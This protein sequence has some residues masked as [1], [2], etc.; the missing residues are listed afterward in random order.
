[1]IKY[2]GSFSI[3]VSMCGNI[4][5]KYT[6]AL[7]LNVKWRLHYTMYIT[8][9]IIM[10]VNFTEIHIMYIVFC[11]RRIEVYFYSYYHNI[12]NAGRAVNFDFLLLILLR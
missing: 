9:I 3:K 11:T 5:L 6:H 12:P 2:T 4:S 10:L 8:C 7:L 1:M